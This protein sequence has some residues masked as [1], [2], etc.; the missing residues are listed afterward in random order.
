MSSIA[1]AFLGGLTAM[2]FGVIGLF[3][4]KFWIR[5][6]DS[7]FIAFAIAFWL[8]AISQTL[9]ALRVVPREEQSWIYVL[10]LA[11]FVLIAIAIVR[12]NAVRDV[13]RGGLTP[14]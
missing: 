2:S 4:V 12:K 9:V 14:D 6:R 8:L 11:A 13:R 7:L 10:R 1:G 3:F 5:T